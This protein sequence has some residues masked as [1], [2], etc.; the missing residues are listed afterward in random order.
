MGTSVCDGWPGVDANGPN[1]DRKVERPREDGPLQHFAVEA[2]LEA[3]DV[4]VSACVAK[5]SISVTI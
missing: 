5:F 3:S 2:R 4:V 1:Q